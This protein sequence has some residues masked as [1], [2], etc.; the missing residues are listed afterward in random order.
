ME[1]I[2]ES[3]LDKMG[4][5]KRGAEY[6]K[7]DAQFANLS[8]HLSR[9]VKA[10]D[11]GA[12]DLS[13]TLSTEGEGPEVRRFERA[14][15]A[16]PKVALERIVSASP[17]LRDDS[18][19]RRNEELSALLNSAFGF[20]MVK[21][22]FVVRE[23][24]WEEAKRAN[25]FATRFP[26]REVHYWKGRADKSTRGLVMLYTD[27]PASS[28]WAN[29]VPPGEQTDVEELCPRGGNDDDYRRVL[30]ARLKQRLV[31]YINDNNVPDIT[32]GDIVW[33]GIMDWGREPYGA[34]NHAWRPERKYWETMAD[35]ADINVRGTPDGPR[36]HVCGEAYSDYHGFI[37]GSLR[38]ATYTLAQILYPVGKRHAIAVELPKMLKEVGGT[39]PQPRDGTRDGDYI[40]DLKAWIRNLERS[41]LRRS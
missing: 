37:E 7:N 40:E 6:V 17:N 34:A 15:L 32:A 22:F 23:R 28:F 31:H 21:V 36:I 29:Y 30:R 13:L 8:I 4:Y 20:P 33:C 3:L 26:T 16:V 1:C 12:R 19:G 41:R 38:S 5:E 35:L 39:P 10:I 9:T 25:W 14:V 11:V 18:S 27:R 2:V 24:W